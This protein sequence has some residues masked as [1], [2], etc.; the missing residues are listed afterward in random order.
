MEH[1]KRKQSDEDKSERPA[2]RRR[3]KG[4]AKKNK[5]VAPERYV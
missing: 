1:K 4:R 2:K 3:T 5:M